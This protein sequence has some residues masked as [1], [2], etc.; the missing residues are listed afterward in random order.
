MEQPGKGIF[1]IHPAPAPIA[2]LL[3]GAK[4]GERDC[5][6]CGNKKV[7]LLVYACPYHPDGATCQDCSAHRMSANAHCLPLPTESQRTAGT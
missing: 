1:P 3:R 6:G 2:C 4:I 7:R 5:L